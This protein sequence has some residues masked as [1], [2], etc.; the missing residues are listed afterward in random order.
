MMKGFQRSGRV[1]FPATVESV[2]GNTCTINVDGLSISDVRLRA[3]ID[4]VADSV[5]LVPAVSAPVLVGSLSDGLDNLFIVQVDSISEA[6]LKIN[7]TVFKLDKNGIEINSGENGGMVKIDEM[8]KWMQKVYSDLQAL[9]ALLSLH[10]VAGNG[11]PLALTFNP[12]V[13]SPQRSAFEN[14]KVKH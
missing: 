11:A 1:F 8:V 6:H 9:K 10:P 4:D 5:L 2:E 12:S 14:K 13:P 7:E 3:T